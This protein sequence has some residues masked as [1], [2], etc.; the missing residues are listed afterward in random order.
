MT[1][2]A[3]T[4]PLAVMI[5]A[6]GKGTR[7]KSD[8]PKVMH[9]LANRSMI[10]HVAA[11]CGTL[12]PARMV[13]VVAPGMEPV[14]QEAAK[15]FSGCG[16]AIQHEQLGTGHAVRIGM[17][18]LADFQGDVLV[19]YGDTPLLT[20]STLSHLLAAKREAKAAIA[21]S[22][23]QPLDPAGYGRLVMSKPPFVERIVECKDA[24][25]KEKSIGWVW[26]GV[27]AFDAAFLREGLAQLTPSPVT[28][29]YYLTALLD[30][31]KKRKL[32]SLNVPV[33]VEES[34]GVN[35]RA[36]LAQ[37]EAAL[38]TR[39]RNYAMAEG[40]TLVAP[41]TVFLSADTKLGRD[42]VIHPHVFFGPGVTVANGVEIRSYCHL[43]GASVGAGTVMG[44]F[45]RLRPGAKLAE[46][47]HIGNF[48]EIKQSTLERGAKVNHLTYV[49]D[50][51][52]G[53]S[54]NVGA[55]TITCNY[56]GF[57]K[58]LTDIG[59]GAFIGS[60][61]S[62][63]APV[64][65]GAGAIIGA[66]SVVTQDVPDDAIYVERADASIKDGAAKTFKDKRKK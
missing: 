36:Q 28:G 44:P 35:S 37:A 27:M 18:E 66:G 58:H 29:E 57:N 2:A 10:A 24:N 53:E 55:G 34:M 46:N 48:V 3:H 19:V 47:V 5:L 32:R 63:V 65:V 6:A 42:V 4:S 59:A 43:E 40:A 1:Q 62:L 14:V 56:D 15:H 41:E 17:E 49:G 45:A 11:A 7:M 9:K 64:K 60:N 13:V 25:K 38:Q 26:G 50:A 61:T 16:S 8:L 39:L 21:L 52:V 30:M 22:G 31:A 51:R 33:S 23:M 12:N 54:A 20:S